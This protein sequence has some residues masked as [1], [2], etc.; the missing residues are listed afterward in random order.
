MNHHEIK[1]RK[2]HYEN[3]KA[4]TKTF[5]IRENDR[6]Y[7]KG[8]KVTMQAINQD[9]QFILGQSPLTFKIGDVY[10]IENNRVEFSLLETKVEQI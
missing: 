5:E 10:P 9:G 3:V 6:A 1:I 4:G 8:D 2:E 7:Q